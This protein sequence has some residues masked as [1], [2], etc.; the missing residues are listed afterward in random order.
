CSKP[1]PRR[2]GGAATRGSGSGPRSRWR[3]PRRRLRRSTSVSAPTA[4]RGRRCPTTSRSRSAPACRRRCEIRT[5]AVS[6]QGPSTASSR[7][8]GTRPRSTTLPLS[9][10]STGPRFGPSARSPAS[11]TATTTADPRPKKMLNTLATFFSRPPWCTWTDREAGG[12]AG[13]TAPAVT[14]SERGRGAMSSR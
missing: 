14:G 1:G 6:T 11:S 2:P 12:G 10:C 3:T 13:G 9:T 8:A 4:W 7:A 5:L